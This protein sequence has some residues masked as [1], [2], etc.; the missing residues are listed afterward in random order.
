[1]LMAAQ[2]QALRT[3]AIKNRIDKRDVSLV[4]N[5]KNQLPML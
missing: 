5:E 4:E 2:D 3:N 1:M